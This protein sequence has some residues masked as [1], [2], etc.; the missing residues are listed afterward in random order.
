MHLRLDRRHVQERDLEMA[1][2][3]IHLPLNLEMSSDPSLIE[4]AMKYKPATVTLVP[5]DPSEVTTQ[6]GMNLLPRKSFYK[7]VISQLKTAVQEISLFIDPDPHQVETA[8]EIG[9][10]SIELHTGSYADAT[11]EKKRHIEL[12]HLVQNSRL[13]TRLGLF[14][15]AGHGLTYLNIQPLVHSGAFQ[16]FSIGHSIV[17]RAVFV[18]LERAIKD[19]LYLIQND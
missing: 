4:I 18:G 13:G 15:R 3:C 11:T 14:V 9:A 19:M 5:E 17:A 6:G 8:A 16:E 7:D 2:N 1:L 10:D 12:E